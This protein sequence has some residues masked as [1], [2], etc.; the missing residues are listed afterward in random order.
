[1]ESEQDV[2]AFK[3]RIGSMT[4]R[5]TSDFMKYIN[6]VQKVSNIV[7]GTKER[8]KR[9]MKHR[10]ENSN[11]DSSDT[12]ELNVKELNTGEGVR[13]KLQRK[14][15]KNIN[16]Y[17]YKEDL[18]DDLA[19]DSTDIKTNVLITN[20]YNSNKN[21]T[22]VSPSQVSNQKEKT[23]LKDVLN[24]LKNKESIQQT[25][26]HKLEQQHYEKTGLT[27]LVKDARKEVFSFEK[28]KNM[29]VIHK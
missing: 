8:K 10:P 11:S 17:S 5:E 22:T 28:K 26:N 21:A 9:K 18:T 2:D 7:T 16:S 15:K 27:R 20:D 6:N 24:E 29:N 1:M 12:S 4:R 19:Y 23:S 13:K 3:K 14:C 25:T